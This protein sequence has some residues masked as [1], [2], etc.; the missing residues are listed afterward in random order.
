MV[1]GLLAPG[2]SRAGR[3]VQNRGASRPGRDGLVRDSIGATGPGIVHT[4]ARTHTQTGRNTGARRC[5]SLL[6]GP[7]PP[8]ILKES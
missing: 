6:S 8:T 4:H 3:L 1:T 5:F 7:G 2:P